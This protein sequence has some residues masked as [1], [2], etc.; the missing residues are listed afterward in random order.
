VGE[1]YSKAVYVDISLVHWQLFVC[2]SCSFSDVILSGSA[3]DGG[4]YVPAE[5][6]PMVTVGELDRLAPLNYCERALRIL[7]RIL[8]PN[9]V[10]PSLLKHYA[11]TAFDTGFC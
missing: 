5:D 3:P 6:L 10:H 11:Q 9:D 7:E 1:G 8:H 4:L 2:R